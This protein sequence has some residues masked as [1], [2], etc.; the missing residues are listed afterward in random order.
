MT[1]GSCRGSEARR[2]GCKLKLRIHRR[3]G[4]GVCWCTSPY[5]ERKGGAPSRPNPLSDRRNCGRTAEMR[6]RGP[7]CVL[8]A[9]GA[10]A[11]DSDVFTKGGPR[12]GVIYRAFEYV[13]PPST[14][15][16]GASIQ[17]HQ[18]R[19][20]H[21]GPHIAAISSTAGVSCQRR[22]QANGRRRDRT[23][24]PSVAAL[25]CVQADRRLEQVVLNA[26]AKSCQFGGTAGMTYARQTR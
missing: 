15:R 26:D 23:R 18:W 2:A 8:G 25:E 12:R 24:G 3:G 14:G 22:E 20:A 4:V 17:W 19:S 21:E 5:I 6:R 9:T 10:A 7:A 16:R 1:R 11:C 13:P